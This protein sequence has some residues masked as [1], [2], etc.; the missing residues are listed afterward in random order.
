MVG[1][2]ALYIV[3][4]DEY[5]ST[6]E[7][8]NFLACDNWWENAMI[9]PDND[10]I[11]RSL[12]VDEELIWR[13][14]N[15]KTDR[16]G[17]TQILISGGGG[18]GKSNLLARFREH[19]PSHPT[20]NSL[21][22]TAPTG[23][24]ALN[25]DGETIHRALGL[26]IADE[27][28]PHYFKEMSKNRFRYK[29]TWNFLLNTRVLIIDEVSMIN[30]SM[31]EMLDYLFRSARGNSLPFGGVIL[32]MF[33]DFLQLPPVNK[34]K[35]EFQVKYIFQTEVWNDMN[36]ARIFLNRNYRQSDADF[37]KALDDVRF[38]RLTAESEKLL[39]TRLANKY[40]QTEMKDV[41][42]DQI[43]P[44]VIFAVKRTVDERNS[45]KLTSIL[46]TKN[47]KLSTFQPNLN[48]IARE[49]KKPSP[50][51][52]EMGRAALKNPKTIEDR[53]P[54]NVVEVCEGA[55]VM[56]RCNF[57]HT[58]GVVNG[59]MGIV[60]SIGPDYI[61]ILFYVKSKFLDNTID[62][63]R[64]AFKTKFSEDV[65][66]CLTQFPITLAWATTIHK[67]QCLTLDSL[68][69]SP[70]DCFE[71]GQF[72]VAVSRVR[73][74]E[75]L[76]LLNFNRQNIKADQAAIKFESVLERLDEEEEEEEGEEEEEEEDTKRQKI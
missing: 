9:K 4:R 54:V 65:E 16:N 29:K 73:K 68:S 44:I 46:K 63:A 59:T 3:S 25:I 55:Q 31:F 27:T 57:Y 69:V 10:N 40:K 17:P 76:T 32:I 39:R 20:L 64:H 72:Y 75:D 2:N 28:G 13:C 6:E 21:I 5:R 14:I 15:G 30:P 7:D 38:G 49:G 51:D 74:L 26:G 24:A 66:L 47:L 67:V 36:K 52:L 34:S 35:D 18:A 50:K 71:M 60:K 19:F 53:F 23:V 48:A 22:V 42:I 45:M 33:G 8:E 11:S 43:E 62:V 61:S 37:I 41:S 56:M 58:L 70:Q 12:S 1:K